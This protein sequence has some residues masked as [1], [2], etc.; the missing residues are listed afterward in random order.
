MISYAIRPN[1]WSSKHPTIIAGERKTVASNTILYHLNYLVLH[2]RLLAVHVQTKL[3][4]QKEMRN[5]KG[6]FN[7]RLSLTNWRQ[8]FHCLWWISAY[9]VIDSLSVK[10]QRKFQGFK[11]FLT[12]EEFP[13][14]SRVWDVANVWMAALIYLCDVMWA[15]FNKAVTENHSKHS[16]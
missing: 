8:F 11:A 2:I 16:C 1:L 5:Q 7:I 6:K 12:V 15:H 9:N 3:N 13:E 4:T 10:P 14:K